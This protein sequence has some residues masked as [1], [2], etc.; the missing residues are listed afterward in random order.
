MPLR[1][2][3]IKLDKQDP[4]IQVVFVGKYI[5]LLYTLWNQK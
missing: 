3:H 4:G 5:G 1:D 2:V